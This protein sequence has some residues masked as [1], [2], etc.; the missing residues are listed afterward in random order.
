[1]NRIYLATFHSLIHLAYILMPASLWGSSD[2]V[3]DLLIV[4]YWNRLMNDRLPVNFN[5]LLQG[6]YM[7]MPSAR[8]GQEGEIGAGYSWVA[9]Y[10]NYNLRVQFLDVLEITGNYRI[11]TGIEDPILSKYGYGDLTDKGA[12][13]KLSFFRPED[14]DYSLPGLAIG[15]NDVIGTRNFRSRYIVLTQVFLDCHLELSLG[16]GWHRLR[17]WFGGAL[18][19][20]FR[21]C[22]WRWLQPLSVL[23]EYDATPYK[24][25]AV[26]LHPKGRKCKSP[27]NIGMKYRLGD[28]LDFSLSLVRGHALAFS[29]SSFYNFGL[30]TG[31]LPKIHDPLPCRP[32]SCIESKGLVHDLTVL[33]EEQGFDL[34]EI[35]SSRASS[36]RKTLRLHVMNN[37]YR[38]EGDVRNRMTHLLAACI[39]FDIDDVIIVIEADALPIQEYF[40]RMEFVRQYAEKSI[41]AYE[42]DILTPLRE[43]SSYPA[44]EF[45]LL[46]KRRPDLWNLEIYPKTLSFFGSA[47][48]KFKGALGIHIDC[49]GFLY[50]NIYYSL[51]LGSIFWSN[52]HHISGVDRLNPSQIINVRTDIVEYYQRKGV[53]IDEAYVQK[54]WRLGRGWYARLAAGLFEPEYGGLAC[55]CLYYPVHSCWAAGLEA[56]YERKRT[57]GGVGFTDKVRKLIGFKKTYRK[58]TGRQFFLNFYYNHYDARLDLNLKAGKFMANDWGARFELSRY[59]PSGLRLNVWYTWTNAHDK[60]NGKTYHD[61]GVSFSMPLD[62]FYTHSETARFGNGMSAW[63]RDVGV[64]AGNGKNLYDLI[65]Q[66]RE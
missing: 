63:L 19:M 57:I 2:L 10:A 5:H 40:Y 61:K 22:S 9:P 65:N 46:F 56:A 6:G 54:N 20:P 29:V 12:N 52:M 58:F 23:A 11:F 45:N 64:I 50:E 33:L 3:R 25:A 18:W 24:D 34:L 38:L 43:V 28:Q 13:V 44:K 1:M 8:M 35:R 53:T 41:G 31:F 15:F 30:T 49:N 7:N 55:E 47:K 17:R 4:D 16:Y 51:L 37:N 39:P 59:F 21:H 66:E 14:S 42:L 36:P 62:I 60:I 26:E 32:Q 48:G 27:L